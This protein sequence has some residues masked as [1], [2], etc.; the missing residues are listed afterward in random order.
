M[1]YPFL[2]EHHLHSIFCWEEKENSGPES[3]CGTSPALASTEDDFLKSECSYL[4]GQ[5]LPGLSE[6]VRVVFA[7]CPGC[8]GVE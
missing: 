3:A 2:A 4:L 8:G 5:T 7:Q 1:I 6:F